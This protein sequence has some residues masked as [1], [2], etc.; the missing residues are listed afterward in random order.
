MPTNSTASTTV[1]PPIVVP[2]SEAAA[3]ISAEHDSS[4]HTTIPSTPVASEVCA[5]A[6][7]D[8]ASKP[9]AATLEF[10]STLAGTPPAW[11]RRWYAWPFW[12]L[13]RGWDHSCLCVLLAIV[14]AVPVVQLASLGYL[15]HAAAR[16]A[17]RKPWSAALPGAR[18]AGKLGVF[19]LLATLLWLPVALV[20][21]LS[22]S[23]QLLLPD[24][25]ESRRWRLGAFVITLAWV[26]HC[27]W[28]AMRGGK[29]RH[30]LWPAPLKF[31]RQFFRR[32]TWRRAS[33]DLYQ[34]TLGLHFPR[35]WWLGARAAAGALIWIFIPV[36]M[37]IIGQRAQ[38][39][40]PA[41]VV[42]LIG[43]LAMTIILLYLPDRKSV[44]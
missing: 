41:A 6:S 42:G 28:A 27:A 33:E 19:A 39:F 34:F 37:M 1:Q 15:L 14:A 18:L 11:P 9:L 20:N 17:A 26:T 38:D 31:L 35:L 4:G 3:D 13:G 44:V 40:P 29:L 16:L 43:A 10:R 21:D 32:A 23:S 2:A 24:S 12:L 30:F 22:Y 7:T 25:P 5:L 36:S 8:S